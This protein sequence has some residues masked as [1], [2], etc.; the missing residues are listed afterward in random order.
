MTDLSI[1][2]PS[3]PRIVSEEKFKGIYEIDGLYPGYGY[4]LGNSL[5]RLILSSLP[6][7]AVTSIKIKDVEH[8]FSTISG[9]KEDVVMIILN[10]KKIRMKMLTR[11]P[12]TVTLK[13]KGA[14]EVTAGMIETSGQVEVL[15]P[16]LVI[17]TLT[18][19]NA[20]L[21]IEMTVEQGI[22]FVDK[23]L[24]SKNRVDIGTIYLDANFTPVR[25]ASYEVENMRV[26]D[27]T[28]F[29]RL[30]LIIETDGTIT[31]H[32]ALAKSIEI[33]IN[34][35]KAVVGFEETE[36]MDE[37]PAKEEEAPKE[38]LDTEFLKTRIEGLG[39]SARTMNALSGANIRTV[40]GLA[41][42]KEKDI[43]EIEG[44]G[45]KGAAEIKRVLAEH[46]ITLK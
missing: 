39:L 43:L 25:R 41:R 6:G 45:A 42:K 37:E 21:E 4:T 34:Q 26:G 24:V 14:K 15:N 5:R 8:E 10:V 19:K 20:E 31:P 11:E 7:A 33:M 29:N 36:E 28:N 44:L 16:D 1:I 3:K 32:D 35:L 2:L 38:E 40:G 9:I 22:G 30:R 17:A 46:G 13:A 27:K 18:D 12:Q 23:D